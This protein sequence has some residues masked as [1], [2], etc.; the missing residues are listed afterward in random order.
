MFVLDTNVV[1]ELRK[2]GLGKTSSA[3]AKWAA[4]ADLS[5][6]Y[7]STATIVEL[8]VG[9]LRLEKKDPQ[10]AWVLRQ[11]LSNFVLPKFHGRILPVTTE[12]ALRAAYSLEN[13]D[14]NSYPDALIAATAYVHKMV[15][16]TRNQKHFSGAGMRIINPW[17]T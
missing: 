4:D 2:V 12:I 3:F 17:N 8:E 11:W 10:Q 6:H 15:I 13:T 16:V 5:Q 9:I 1:S 14:S 7:L